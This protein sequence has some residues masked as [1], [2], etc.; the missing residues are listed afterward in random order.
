VLAVKYIKK[1]V[2]KEPIKG[3]EKEPAESGE[4]FFGV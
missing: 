3:S 2:L 1:E 4:F